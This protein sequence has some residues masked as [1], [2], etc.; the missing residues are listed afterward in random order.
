MGRGPAAIP[1]TLLAL[2]LPLA[3]IAGPAFL[4]GFP[5]ILLFL[6]LLAGSFE[7]IGWTGYANPRLLAR[8][9]VLQAGLILGL[10]WAFWHLLVDFRYNAGSLG[11]PCPLEFVVVYLATLTPYTMLMTWVFARTQNLLLSI[12]LHASFTGWLMVLFPATEATQSLAWQ[13]GFAMILWLLVVAVFMAKRASPPVL[14][15][16]T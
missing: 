13:A 4:P 9:G 3:A 15:D 14:G 2:L 12:L 7:E 1:V 11:A 8:F 6:G 16:L 5:L 10:A